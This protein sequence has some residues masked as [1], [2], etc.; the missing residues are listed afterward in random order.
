MRF[1]KRLHC[2][3]PGGSSGK[4]SSCNTG[5]LGS[6]P[7]FGRS[8]GEGNGYPLHYSGL[9]NSMDCIVHGITKNQTCLSNFHFSIYVKI[10]NRQNSLWLCMCVLSHFSHVW[11]FVI[12]RTI[13]CQAPLSIGILQARILKWVSMPSSRPRNWSHISY[14]SC[15]DRR[16]LYH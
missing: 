11:L 13:A 9:E 1:R 16:V 8:P 10:E 3:F 12:P 4:E 2:S 5:D 6:V 7:G 15:I 14:I